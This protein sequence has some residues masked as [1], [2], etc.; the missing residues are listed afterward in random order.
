MVVVKGRG[1]K[2]GSALEEGDCAPRSARGFLG[3]SK[4]FSGGQYDCVT[5]EHLCAG[6]LREETRG[7]PVV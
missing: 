7:S 3:L 4:P 1:W 2:E 6:P 5:R